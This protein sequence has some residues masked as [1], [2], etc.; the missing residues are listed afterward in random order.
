[1]LQGSVSGL[2]SACPKLE[3]SCPPKRTIRLIRGINFRDYCYYAQ[4]LGELLAT[5]RI[6]D[7]RGTCLTE[8]VTI[9]LPSGLN[10]AEWRSP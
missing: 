1:M 2:H 7:P 8:A 10:S 9:R 4:R 6:P 3:R 5:L